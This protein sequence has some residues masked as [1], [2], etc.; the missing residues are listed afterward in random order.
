V[1]VVED[2]FRCEV[3][4]AGALPATGLSVVIDA[5]GE[6]QPHGDVS[7]ARPGAF[8]EALERVGERTVATT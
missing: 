7:Q 6:N 4:E 5:L 8:W 2:V 3:G 1:Q